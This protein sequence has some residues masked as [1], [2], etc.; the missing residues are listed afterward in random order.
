MKA[1]HVG[2]GVKFGGV[3]A[4]CGSHTGSRAFELDATSLYRTEEGK[5]VV[6]HPSCAGGRTKSRVGG[7]VTYRT[8][9]KAT[10]TI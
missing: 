9:P 5:Y 8:A 3:C 1:T 10:I 7:G 6:V 2:L 4:V